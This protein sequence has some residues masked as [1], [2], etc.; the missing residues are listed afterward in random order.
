MHALKELT[1]FT[2]YAIL[3][4]YHL[5]LPQILIVYNIKSHLV[6]IVQAKD[7]WESNAADLVG[8]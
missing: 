4:I 5:I 1:H 8:K 6:D 3:T 2:R 7:T